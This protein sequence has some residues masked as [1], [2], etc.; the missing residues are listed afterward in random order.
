M[1]LTSKGT[2]PVFDSVALI[3][4]KDVFENGLQAITTKQKTAEQVAKDM[5]AAQDK[6]K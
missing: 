5:Q 3:P 1:E 2:A 4:V 6:A